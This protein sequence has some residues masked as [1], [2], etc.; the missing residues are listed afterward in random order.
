MPARTSTELGL[1]IATARAALRLSRRQIWEASGV[2]V[3]MIRKS[4][5]GER[6]PSDAILE[7]L[8][9]ALRTTPEA[10]L[11]GP[12][13]SDSRVHAAI[14]ALR[15][16]VAAYDL[17]D[18]GPVRP[19]D[20]LAAAVQAA[21]DD[22][23][24]SRYARLS[25]QAPALLE[26]LFRAVDQAAGDERRRAAH[27]LA[28]AVRAADAVAY[29]HGYRDL[30]ARMVELMRWA[31]DR[32]EDD[33]LTATAAYVR[34]ETHLASGRLTAGLRG[35]RAAVDEMPAPTTTPLAAAGAALHMR[36]AVVAGRLRDSSAAHDHLAEADRLG[37]AVPERLYEG[38]AVGPHSLRIHRLAVAVELAEPGA[39]QAAVAEAGRWAPP[40]DLGAE[41]RSHYWIDLARAQALIG[42]RQHAHES[43]EAAR[44]IAPQ[45]VREHG[46]VRDLLGTLVRLDRGKTARL[47][48][49]A[50]WAQAV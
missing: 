12:G 30:S 24:N 2:S 13:R 43:L 20:E 22:R 18:D 41:R 5:E 47:V 6:V 40:L 48:A 19:L 21:T 45:H 15:T 3:S 37:G 17:P 29:K 28:L 10:L 36:A 42:R 23:V 16:A 26:E 31:A 50:R 11:D 34:T 38:T 49:L 32:A 35:L 39:L 4:E 27:L 7:A 33:S 1:R 14:P 25:E 46:Q 44:Q 8:A 9:R